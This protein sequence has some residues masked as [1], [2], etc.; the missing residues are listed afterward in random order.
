LRLGFL[1]FADFGWG[2]LDSATFD[3][4]LAEVVEACAFLAQ[5]EGEYACEIAG[6]VWRVVWRRKPRKKRKVVLEREAL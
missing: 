1:L 6:F 5:E 3:D 4:D 2:D